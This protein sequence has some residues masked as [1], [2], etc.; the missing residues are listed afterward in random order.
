M[1][2]LRKYRTE[3][4]VATAGMVSRR[5]E[6]N[7]NP[8]RLEASMLSHGHIFSKID[9][10]IWNTCATRITHQHVLV[11]CPDCSSARQKLH[12]AYIRMKLSPEN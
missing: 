10:Q 4:N 2:K 3:I 11:D 6:V 5:Q 7:I 12:T 1:S 8:L 9:P